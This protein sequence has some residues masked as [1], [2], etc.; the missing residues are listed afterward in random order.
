MLKR[1]SLLLYAIGCIVS[2]GSLLG[3][4]AGAVMMSSSRIHQASTS[5]ANVQLLQPPAAR[6]DSGTP[7]YLLQPA[8]GSTISASGKSPYPNCPG[9]PSPDLPKPHDGGGGKRKVPPLVTTCGPNGPIGR[10]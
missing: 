4:S 6:G 10:G 3:A 9:G 2:V 7:S 5:S 8:G 1:Q